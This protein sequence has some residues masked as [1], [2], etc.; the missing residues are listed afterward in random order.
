MAVQP[1]P[2]TAAGSHQII[3][4]PPCVTGQNTH[5]PHAG[6]YL[7]MHVGR[8]TAGSA[9]NPADVVHPKEGHPE[10]GPNGMR[11]LVRKEP[12]EDQNGD[13]DAAFSQFH[14]FLELRYGKQPRP[15]IHQTTGDADSAMAVR[16]RFDHWN[17]S[18]RGD[19]FADPVVVAAQ[20]V[21]MNPGTGSRV[22]VHGW[23]LRRLSAESGLKT[24]WCDRAGDGRKT[25]WAYSVRQS[26]RSP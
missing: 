19:R 24:V 11:K 13:I 22:H 3:D 14:G 15:L 1:F 12:P 26:G 21:K 23:V 10:P 25:P 7:D 4:Q 6:I 18:G 8:L 5:P 17:Q 16:V 9:F 2:D 20:A